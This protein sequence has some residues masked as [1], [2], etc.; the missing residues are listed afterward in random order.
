VSHLPC[1]HYLRVT[2]P[3]EHSWANIV[4]ELRD[5][6]W[7]EMFCRPTG[8]VPGPVQLQAR[9]GGT[10]WRRAIYKY[11]WDDKEHTRPNEHVAAN[12]LNAELPSYKSGTTD[13]DVTWT[14]KP[15]EEQAKLIA[16][17][18]TGL[19]DTVDAETGLRIRHWIHRQRDGPPEV[20]HRRAA[21]VSCFGNVA[22]LRT[23]RQIHRE[24]AQVLYGE[25]TF[26]FDTR[27]MPNPC[28][29][30]IRFGT[31][32]YP[33]HRRCAIYAWRDNLRSQKPV[34]TAIDQLLRTD[35]YQP[36]D[37]RFDPLRLF[38]GQIGRRH[39]SFITK[40]KIDGHFQTSTGWGKGLQV[41]DLAIV[42][43]F[44]TEILRDM[45]KNLRTITLHMGYK[46]TVR[47]N[48][49]VADIY[50]LQYRDR[51]DNWDERDDV[52]VCEAVGNLAYSI[53]WLKCLQLGDCKTPGL[54]RYDIGWGIS[55][56]WIEYVKV[57]RQIQEAWE[58][59]ERAWANE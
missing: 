32:D 21:V 8:I 44:Y 15:T 53:P 22:L 51:H 33:F 3:V 27:G 37:I 9:R 26:V 4:L 49:S 29:D 2:K 47:R 18:A 52:N 12:N 19:P 24:A 6:I 46:C 7:Q 50:L 59:E 17:G 48:N 38:F 56:F 14:S 35:I 1:N 39:A 28:P 25:N 10:V 54:T 16:N 11:E 40:I 34:S 13:L 36:G 30:F 20:L 55:T 43:P 57:R 58:N 41:I 31:P 45:C 23:C 5:T 42:L